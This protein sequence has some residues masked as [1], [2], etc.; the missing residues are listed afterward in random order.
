VSAIAAYHGGWLVGDAV[1]GGV[2]WY[3]NTGALKQQGLGADQIVA[4][5]DG[6]RIAYQ[7]GGKIHIGLAS[8]M[9]EGEQ[10]VPLSDPLGWPV[11]FLSD[12]ALVFNEGGAVRTEPQ[13]SNRVPAAMVEATAVSVDDVVAGQD[14]ERRGMLWSARTGRVLWQGSDWVV[15]GFSTDGKRAAATRNSDDGTS[16]VAILDTT[17]GRVVAQHA[18]GAEDVVGVDGALLDN[19]GSLLVP[20]ADMGENRTVLRL[21]ADGRLTRATDILPSDLQ[22]DAENIVLLTGR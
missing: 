22:H 16:A 15:S 5:G 8:G 1:M 4:S 20:V 18:F 13:A 2:R 19:D 6:L 10:T 11:G 21:A 3:D 9:G 12:G 7:T 17:T 14:G